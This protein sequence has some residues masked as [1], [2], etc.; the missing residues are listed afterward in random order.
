MNSREM[1]IY[2]FH[3]GEHREVYKYMGAHIEEDGVIFRVWAP[4]ARAVA[5]VGDFNNWTG[6]GAYM[7]RLNAEGIWELKIPNLKKYDLY[8]FRVEQADGNVVYKADPYA[9]YS[10]MR[11][12]TASIIYDIPEFK[13]TD[14]RWLNKRITGLN[15]PMNIYEVHLGSW[16]KNEKGEWLTYKE[17]ADQLSEYVK[18]MNYT[19]VEIMPVNEHPLDA[20][21]GYQGTG[22]YS[23]TSR[24]GTPE[25]FM[26]L[27]NQMH[28]NNIGVI[29]DWVPGHFC[30]DSH[31]LYKFDGTATYE[32][33]DERIGENKEW[34]T[35]NFDLTRYEVQSFLISNVSY[36]FNEF[37]IDGIR[38]DAV[39]NMLYLPNVEGL[40]NQFGG[41]ENLGAVDFFKK[42]NSIIHDDFPNCVVMAEDSTA[43]PNVTK[44]PVDGGLG[45]D[46]K[47]NMG[48]MNDTLKY[49]ETD[50]LFRK[51]H[52]GKLTFSFMY[53]FSEN[54]VLPLSHDEVVH[55]KKSIVNKMP[56]YFGAQLANTRALYSYQMLHPGKKLNFMGNEFAQGLEWR[57]YEQLE[58]QLLETEENKKMQD[59]CKALNKMYL[60]EK[61]LWE[62]SW[63]TFEWI[64]HENYNENI[65][66]FLRKT[67]DGSEKII[68]IFNF[69]GEAKTGYRIGVPENKIY[70]ILLN[71]DD[72]KYGGTNFTKR[73]KYKPLEEPWNYREQHIE[74]DIQANSVIFLKA[75]ERKV[76]KGDETEGEKEK[77][78]SRSKKNTSKSKKV[79]K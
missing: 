7:N 51:D 3:R 35:C 44:H 28:K 70:R 27:V 69:S 37:H 71:S 21:W 4:H 40:T 76:K 34:G 41:K 57:F 47:W 31:G 77:E 30:K 23:V 56:G 79:E 29:L 32:Y 9:F 26:Y 72:E 36:W 67:K 59:Y 64:E 55:G 25:D 22:Y 48:W 43:W 39:A 45:F 74:V 16:R 53:A 54:Y 50:P 60:K 19:H 5:V 46:N 42:F 13:W 2:L 14:K 18:E 68:G 20:S 63:D 38:I 73:K 75:E 58:W 15:K 1:D 8:K 52:H 12:N 33:A 10:E 24:Y 17:I 61:S 78:K 11:P 62:D 6:E 49:F 66:A 65:I